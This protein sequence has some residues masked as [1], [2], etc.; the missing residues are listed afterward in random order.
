MKRLIS[1]SI[2]LLCSGNSLLLGQAIENASN[3]ISQSDSIR[4][5]QIYDQAWSFVSVNTDSAY[6][7]SEIAWSIANDLKSIVY[8]SKTKNLQGAIFQVK[9]DYIHSEKTLREGI[10]LATKSGD[11]M[12]L[13]SIQNNYGSLLFHQNNFPEALKHFRLAYDAYLKTQHVE[14]QATTMNNIGMLHE[15]TGDYPGALD[16][17]SNALELKKNSGARFGLL[18]INI[19]NVYHLRQD[20]ERAEEFYNQAVVKL[21]EEGD[22]WN[23]SDVYTDLAELYTNKGEYDKAQA[24]FDKS[25][26]QSR[27]VG[28]LSLSSF[29]LHKKGVL[30]LLQKQYPAAK[31]N[32]SESFNLA[33]QIGDLDNSQHACECLHEVYK[34]TGD[35]RNALYYYELSQTKG[36]SLK[37]LESMDDVMRLTIRH[38]YEM[39]QLADSLDR[40]EEKIRT[41]FSHQAEIKHRKNERNWLIALVSFVV[42]TATVLAS[43][44]RF[45]VRTRKIIQQERERSENLLLNILPFTVAQEL[46]QRGKAEAKLFSDVTVMFTDFC[47]FTELAEKISPT[48]LIQEVDICFQEFD[49]IIMKHGLEKIKTIGDSYMAVAGLPDGNNSNAS[50]TLMAAFEMMEFIKKR[51]GHLSGS[52]EAGLN[53]RIGI[54]SGPVIAGVVGLHKMQYDIWGDTVNT[55]SRVETASEPGRI[56]ISVATHR[57]VAQDN[58]FQF[59]PR[60]R[61]AAKNKGEMDMYFVQ[62]S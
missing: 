9:S 33:E 14:G 51:T 31:K 39:K 15:E 49:K 30:H 26:D 38:E 8:Q 37:A 6:H 1:I 58:R 11:L 13:A 35:Y 44:L 17:Y 46:K 34:Q 40:E 25:Y 41:E 53:M 12:V 42:I 2:L 29:V 3:K 7:Y 19:G 61:I 50:S 18:L 28:S 23:L 56:N 20:F 32:C 24:F 48:E 60:G 16:Y 55:A 22:L 43:R 45:A 36:D 27:Q 62:K 57:L 54:H 5:H 59:I 47:S 52:A 21:N 10:E 4:F